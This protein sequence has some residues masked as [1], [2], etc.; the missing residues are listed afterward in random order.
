MSELD[1]KLGQKA[2]ADKSSVRSNLKA[3]D[4]LPQG[5]KSPEPKGGL[6]P[7]ERPCIINKLRYMPANLQGL[8]IASQLKKQM[9]MK[10]APATRISDPQWRYPAQSELA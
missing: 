2:L 6:A 3:S 9:D 5:R 8:G 4:A 7:P 10:V 1:V